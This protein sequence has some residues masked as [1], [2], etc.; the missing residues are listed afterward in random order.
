LLGGKRLG[1]YG[2]FRRCLA[3]GGAEPV[4]H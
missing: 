1:R 3:C 2:P 4:Q